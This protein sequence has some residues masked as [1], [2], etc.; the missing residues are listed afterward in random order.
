MLPDRQATPETSSTAAPA[1]GDPAPRPPLV[2]ILYLTYKHERFAAEAARSVLEQTYPLLDI[3]ILDDASP[4]GTAD[5]IAREVR[6][7]GRRSDVRFFRNEHNL[8]AFGNV[9]K[10]LS[11]ALGDFVVLFS[12]DDVMLPTLV[13]RMTPCWRD[14]DVSL[15]TAN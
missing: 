1:A 8:G 14:H 4:D 5:I 3:V 9:Q 12:G 6:R 7:H 15:V 11:L 10:G 13:E 2:S